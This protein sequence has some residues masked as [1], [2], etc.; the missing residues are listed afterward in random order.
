MDRL[1]DWQVVDRPARQYSSDIRNCVG[2]LPTFQF[3]ASILSKIGHFAPLSL[4]PAKRFFSEKTDSNTRLLSGILDGNVGTSSWPKP[5]PGRSSKE[6]P[7]VRS[8]LLRADR[9]RICGID[10]AFPVFFHRRSAVRG[11]RG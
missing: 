8:H 3:F 2:G 5:R 9:S 11:H 4:M 10:S 1:V 6:I 7:H